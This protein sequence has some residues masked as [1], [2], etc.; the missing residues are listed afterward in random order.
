MKEL[1]NEGYKWFLSNILVSKGNK[2]N[3]LDKF[4][5]STKNVSYEFIENVSYKNS[6]YQRKNSEEDK[7]ILVKGNL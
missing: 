3:L 2:N 1:T 4:I 5:N 6:N 7:E